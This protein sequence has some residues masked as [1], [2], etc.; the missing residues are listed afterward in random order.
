MQGA[1]EKMA[2]T[3]IQFERCTHLYT[4]T[5]THIYTHIHT[6]TYIY[7]HVHIHTRTTH[8]LASANTLHTCSLYVIV[9]SRQLGLIDDTYIHTGVD[10]DMAHTSIRFGFG[11][12]TTEEEVDHAIELVVRHV[13]R[14]REMSPLWEMV[15]M[16]MC[17]CVY[18]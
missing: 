2:H 5:Y 13:E 16:Y 10:E 12:F 18:I 7:T 11:R 15:C 4:Y 1:F 3:S 14:L 17:T 8:Y 9:F 6:R